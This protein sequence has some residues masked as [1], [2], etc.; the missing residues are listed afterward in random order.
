MKILFTLEWDESAERTDCGREVEWKA[1][2]DLRR[3]GCSRTCLKWRSSLDSGTLKNEIFFK[4]FEKGQEK[5]GNYSKKAGRLGWGGTF[6]LDRT[7]WSVG[8]GRPSYWWQTSTRS[9]I[10]GQ[11]N[12]PCDDRHSN[13]SDKLL[14]E[15]RRRTDTGRPKRDTPNWR[16]RWRIRQIAGDCNRWIDSNLQKFVDKRICLVK[17]NRICRHAN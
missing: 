14:P 5:R 13:R 15:N 4:L 11:P 2:L 9:P 3:A 6:E 12:I 8:V 16:I 17:S 10:D 7:R 1:I